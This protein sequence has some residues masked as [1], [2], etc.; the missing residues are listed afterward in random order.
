M[1][2]EDVIRD[3][4]EET[5]TSLTDKL[6][7]LEQKVVSTVDET[8]SA[9]S[10]TVAAV[11]DTVKDT[12]SAVVDTVAQVKDTVA[13]TVHSV[14]DSVKG[15]LTSVRDFFS[16]Q[17]NPWVG[18]G[19]SVLAGFVVGKFVLPPRRDPISGLVS[20]GEEAITTAPPST[21]AA[22]PQSSRSDGSSRNGGHRDRRSQ[23]VQSRSQGWL[24]SLIGQLAP[25]LNKFKGMALGMLL[26]ASRDFVMQA[27]PQQWKEQAMGV[28]HGIASKLHATPE[29]LNEGGDEHSHS[30]YS[31]DNGGEHAGMERSGQRQGKRSRFDR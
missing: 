29:S 1:E 3:Q 31:D 19:A 11:K 16:M 23:S 7:K 8:T 30:S 4:M 27:V 21:A 12:T 6:E 25:D 18:M 10:E 2:N 5:R 28:F 24:G 20:A 15:G 22:A 17:K 13:E 9:V 26:D 14:T